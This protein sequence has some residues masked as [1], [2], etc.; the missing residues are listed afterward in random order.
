M[1]PQTFEKEHSVVGHLVWNWKKRKEKLVTLATPVPIEINQE[2]ALH[3]LRMHHGY[4]Q[5]Y[6]FLEKGNKMTRNVTL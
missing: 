2:G 4:A 1:L 3:D 6:A 5:K